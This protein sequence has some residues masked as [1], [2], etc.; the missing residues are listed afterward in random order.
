MRDRLL[1]AAVSQ[2]F[3]SLIEPRRHP[4][5]F[6]SLTISP[7]EVDVNV[8]PTK[9]EIRFRNA[10]P[11]RNAIVSVLSQALLAA[12]FA[13]RVTA[14]DAELSSPRAENIR[15]SIEA[16]YDNRVAHPPSG[17]P[18]GSPHGAHAGGRFGGRE[19]STLPIQAPEAGQ[20]HAA[21]SLMQVRGTYIVQETGEGIAI[22][23]QHALHERVL[24]G[25]VRKR[26]AEGDLQGQ[27][28]LVPEVIDVTP[29]EKQALEGSRELL[30]KLGIDA[31]SFG[32]DSFAFHS[33]PAVLGDVDRQRLI[34]ELTSDLL[35]EG[36]ARPIERAIDE[37][38]QLLACH[39]AVRAG[40]A[41][42]G[43]QLQALMEKADEAEARFACPH[44][45]PTKLI[46]TFD[47][48]EKRFKRK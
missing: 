44:G 13:P 45:R 47:E 27:R 37:M 8:H 46:L 23:D 48:L 36:R 39:A 24:Y 14:P 41:L 38:A 16:F 17:S 4:V 2:A 40:D 11:V 20:L 26:L 28:L 43:D 6:L 22:I 19:G 10:G 21:G 1:Q 32:E 31:E 33:F 29:A 12:D 15:R 34:R 5:V 3:R 7:R 18:S 25:E 9:M 35:A 42:S 30:A